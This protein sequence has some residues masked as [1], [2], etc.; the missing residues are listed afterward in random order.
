M[1]DIEF[2]NVDKVEEKHFWFK[3]KRRIFSHFLNKYYKNGLILDSACGT[4]RDLKDLKNSI[5]M[6]YNFYALKYAKKY[7]DKL[8]NGDA[9]FL[10]FKDKTFEIIFSFDLL[11]HEG[12]DFDKVL[13]EYNRV[14]K[15]EGYIFL[16]LPMFNFLYSKHDI[17]VNN[18]IRFDMKDLKKFKNYGFST[19]DK[20]YWNF[21]LF[22]LIVFL[23]K[24]VFQ[25][26]SYDETSDVK[27]TGK[28]TNLLLDKIFSFEF[29]LSKKNILP[30]GVSCFIVLRKE[31]DL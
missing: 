31:V 15:K 10:P 12:I 11:Q 4:G 18:S 6:D 14:L 30:L 9:N 13:K 19:Q 22:P 7:C 28:L 17:A 25:F 29:K 20:I 2:D 16:N 21:V 27:E 23:R 24:F 5:G 8:V 26:F 3:N 1:R